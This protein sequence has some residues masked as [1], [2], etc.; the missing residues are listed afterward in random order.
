MNDDLNGDHTESEEGNNSEN[1]DFDGNQ[2][3]FKK[4]QAN[5]ESAVS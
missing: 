1:P 5:G 4:R 2:F 3:M